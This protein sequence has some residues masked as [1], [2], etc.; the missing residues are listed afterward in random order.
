MKLVARSLLLT[1]LAC[2]GCAP[3][4]KVSATYDKSVPAAKLRRVV[5]SGVN[6]DIRLSR[7]AAGAIAI[8]A[9]K[10]TDAGRSALGQIQI[11]LSR[12]GGDLRIQTQAPESAHAVVDYAIA[13][14]PGLSVASA[15]TENGSIV[16]SGTPLTRVAVE[17][18]TIDTRSPGLT[19][20]KTENGSI[21]AEV[22]GV[23]PDG[24]LL[25]TANGDITLAV[26]PGVGASIQGDVDNGVVSVASGTLTSTSV[27][28]TT[29]LRGV[30]GHGGPSI[31]L[32]V[33]NGDITVKRP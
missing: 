31:E 33:A 11:G 18:G 28:N 17:N 13:V 20:G 10:Q 6:G 19:Y 32:H 29:H 21:A 3:R 27:L 25:A 5:V 1:A 23:T 16:A 15:S 22:H 14:P 9:L 12:Q 30:L 26:A 7:G 4:E 24:L 8:H 2:F